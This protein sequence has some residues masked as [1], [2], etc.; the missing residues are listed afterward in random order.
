MARG[1]DENMSGLSFTNELHDLIKARFLG[2]AH[3][4]SGDALGLLS[5]GLHQGRRHG[6][7]ES[8]CSVGADRDVPGRDDE[9][10]RRAKPGLLRRPFESTQRAFG[11]VHSTTTIALM[12]RGPAPAA[13]S[14]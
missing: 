3:R 14:S 2:L 13:G 7:G 6:R 4:S 8:G 11:S 1:V 12:S 9:E 10:T 5:N